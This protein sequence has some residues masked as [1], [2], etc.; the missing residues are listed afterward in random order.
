MS[1]LFV[2]GHG[3]LF[4]RARLVCHVFL[5]EMPNELVLVDTGL[6]LGD[7]ANPERLGRAWLGQV[8]P[9]L[10]R[11]ETA[12]ARVEALGFSAH[13]VRHVLL[14]HLDRDHA[15][16]IAD[17]PDAKVHV[18][19]NEQR[20]PVRAGR[21]I[22]EQWKTVREWVFYPDTGENWFGFLG[23]RP[24]EGCDDILVV[25]LHGHTPGHAGIAVRAAGKW[26]LHAGDSYYHH[27]QIATPRVSE[28]LALRF[29]QR[30]ADT[31]RAA[32]LANQERLRELKEAHGSEVEIVNSHDPVY[33]DG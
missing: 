20:V 32:R 25:P 33:L 31:D 8:S 16:G 9:R 29:F 6:G 1:A 11:E 26:L 2:N 4:E 21:Y 3:G 7:I 22:P 12:I 28:P 24:L 13:D 10:A 23:V 15:G 19:A 18:H 5:V 14:T 30:R 27:G 17:F